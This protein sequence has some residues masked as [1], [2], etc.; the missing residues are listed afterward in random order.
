MRQRVM[1][2]VT[3][4][5][6]AVSLI[7][8]ATAVTAAAS[9]APAAAKT[10]STAAA[11]S[12]PG[13]KIGKAEILK[14]MQNWTSRKVRYSQSTYVWDLGNTRK[15]RT[16]CSGFAD[17]ALHL[18]TDDN[19]ASLATDKKFVHTRNMNH[20]NRSSFNPKTIQ[21]GDVFD[22]TKDGHAF[23][24]ASWAKDGKH[25]SY[26]NFGGGSSGV[27]PPEY[28]TN[29][30]MTAATLGYEPANNYAVYRYRNVVA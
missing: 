10:A 28:H 20:D 17:M 18:T 4:T 27:A 6:L 21:T 19:T 16:D 2:A 25:F 13:A 5:A 9:A 1:R 30:L 23:V 15:Y 26:Y 7:G 12:K 22:D 11:A 29:A 8:G 14:R 24:F 3:G